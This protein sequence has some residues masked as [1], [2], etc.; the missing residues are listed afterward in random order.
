MEDGSVCKD[1]NKVLDRWAD[2]FQKLLNEG[3]ENVDNSDLLLNNDDN[4]NLCDQITL[5]E[6]KNAVN[7]VQNGKARE[8]MKSLWNCYEMEM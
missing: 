6:V 4:D 5:D 8:L 1:K 3:N 7:S 2:A